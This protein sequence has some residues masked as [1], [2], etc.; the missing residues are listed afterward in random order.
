MIARYQASAAEIVLSPAQILRYAGQGTVP[1]SR[2]IAALLSS[3]L[4]EFSGVAAYRAASLE[5]K[6]LRE[7][8]ELAFGPLCVK[9]KALSTQLKGCD[10]AILFCATVGGALDR[11]LLRYGRQQPSRAVFLDAIGSAAVEAWCDKLVADWGARGKTLRPRFS[12]GYGDFA[13]SCQAELLSLLSAAQTTGISV[14]VGG[15]LVPQKSVT[16]IVG[17]TEEYNNDNT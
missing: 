17:L 2:E 4:A 12:P 7:E 15:M 9:S 6:F 8:E 14:T 13:L 5:L 10:R 16:A 3:C 11:L 1:P